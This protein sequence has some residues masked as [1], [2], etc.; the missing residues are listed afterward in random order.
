MT[1]WTGVGAF[2]YRI[3]YLDVPEIVGI[4]GRS[5]SHLLVE[6][7]LMGW[8]RCECLSEW[9]LG[10]YGG[11]PSEWPGIAAASLGVS[12]LASRFFSLSQFR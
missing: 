10:D 4:Y 3:K 1:E 12:A 7:H 6:S 8:T 11:S 2:G 5:P 9:F